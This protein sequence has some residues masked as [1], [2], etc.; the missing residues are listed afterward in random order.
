[1][2]DMSAPT[3]ALLR[4]AAERL[5]DADHLGP[6]AQKELAELIG[7]FAAALESP[8]TPANEAGKLA[9]G[10][11]ELI[12]ALHPRQEAGLLAKAKGGLEQRPFVLGRYHVPGAF[13]SAAPFFVTRLETPGSLQRIARTA[14]CTSAVEGIG[15]SGGPPTKRTTAKRLS[16]AGPRSMP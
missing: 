14:W 4:E 1:M 16:A 11:A 10:A 8:D 13:L 3:T 7:R 2:A 15:H 12:Q 6:Q 9:H 5:R